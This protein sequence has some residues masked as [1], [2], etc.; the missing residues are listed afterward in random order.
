[1]LLALAYAIDPYVFALVTA[2]VAGCTMVVIA[3]A[4]LGTRR[5]SFDILLAVLPVLLAASLLVTFRWS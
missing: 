5:L 4:M 1:M 2:G 3:A